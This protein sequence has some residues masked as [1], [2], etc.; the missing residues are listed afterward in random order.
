MSLNRMESE[1][2]NFWNWLQT[3]KKCTV[4]AITFHW[5]LSKMILKYCSYWILKII[6][7]N[8]LL[9]QA[10]FWGHEKN[11]FPLESHYTGGRN[12]F[13]ILS[14]LYPQQNILGQTRQ[15]HRHH[16]LGI[17]HLHVNGFNR[18][19]NLKEIVYWSNM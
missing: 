9:I 8:Y 7:N 11:L 4:S 3:L 18:N 13:L 15:K 6:Y 10:I 16:R 12:H 19:M 1:Y 14:L 5:N 2:S 17:Q